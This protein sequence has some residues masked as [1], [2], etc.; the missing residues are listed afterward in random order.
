MLAWLPIDGNSKV[1]RFIHYTTQEYFESIRQERFGAAA[2]QVALSCITYLMYDDIEHFVWAGKWNHFKEKLPLHLQ[3]QLTQKYPFVEYA[4]EHWGHHVREG[5]RGRLT[6]YALRLLRSDEHLMIC[7]H[8]SINHISIQ[9]HSSPQVALFMAASFGL[10]DATRELIAD[11]ADVNCKLD[12]ETA[13]YVACSRGFNEV[14]ELLLNAGA[15]VE[16][17]GGWR[18]TA[19]STAAYHGH[20]EILKKLIPR[21]F[22]WWRHGTALQEATSGGH[23]GTVQFLLAEGADINSPFGT[24]DNLSR[25][26]ENGSESIVQLFLDRGVT[27]ISSREIE[28][29]ARQGHLNIVQSLI[30]REIGKI[31]MKE[32]VRAGFIAA[33]SRGHKEIVQFLDAMDPDVE[34]NVALV[35]ACRNGDLD[36]IQFICN[37]LVSASINSSAFA[38]SVPLP[39]S[40]SHS[41]SQRDSEVNSDF[42]LF[43]IS[44]PELDNKIPFLNSNTIFGLGDSAWHAMLT[45]AVLSRHEDIIAWLFIRRGK[46]QPLD[47][48]VMKASESYNINIVAM[49]WNMFPVKVKNSYVDGF[50]KEIWAKQLLGASDFGNIEVVEI[51]LNR[52]VAVN[53]CYGIKDKPSPGITPLLAAAWKGHPDIVRLLLKHG[54]IDENMKSYTD[55]SDVELDG[56]VLRLSRNGVIGG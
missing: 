30:R 44:S 27:T 34:R 23:L 16:L 3:K 26:V 48:L 21:S 1:I 2:D 8:L 43:S 38:A 52:G 54:A 31:A 12:G 32:W 17:T 22:S 5:S 14:V 47:S 53:P 56:I 36:M 25:A 9:K 42:D 45:E 41:K 51:L 28:I 15:D 49:L 10:E 13:L 20:N 19:L 55:C 50:W 40:E 18:G 33:A 24:G 29:A 37:L 39:G 7:I 35:E 11:G 6:P 4:A 46:L